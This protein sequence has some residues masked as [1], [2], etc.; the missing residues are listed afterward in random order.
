MISDS[1]ALLDASPTFPMYFWT[2]AKHVRWISVPLLTIIHF[3]WISA[4]STC[5]M[6]VE[7]WAARRGR[8]AAT[9]SWLWRRQRWWEPSGGH[10]ARPLFWGRCSCPPLPPP[11]LGRRNRGLLLPLDAAISEMDGATLSVIRASWCSERLLRFRTHRLLPPLV[12]AEATVKRSTGA[13][14][15]GVFI[16]PCPRHCPRHCPNLRQNS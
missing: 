12:L 11:R 3:R 6:C 2:P 15:W 5:P 1:D 7:S 4:S 8:A 14:R 16:Y 10:R 13:W 9:L